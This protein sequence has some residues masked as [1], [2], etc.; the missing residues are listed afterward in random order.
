MLPLDKLD[1]CLEFRDQLYLPLISVWGGRI[2][3]GCVWLFPDEQEGDR[4]RNGAW[5]G[6]GAHHCSVKLQIWE[7]IPFLLKCREEG[8]GRGTE[9]R[10]SLSSSEIRP[11]PVQHTFPTP[12][13]CCNYVFMA[14]LE[15]AVALKRVSPLSTITLWSTSMVIVPS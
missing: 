11:Q 3:V 1:L 14:P 13:S 8:A 6:S 7:M 10:Q 12:T 5:A 4:S 9:A 15:A 2:C